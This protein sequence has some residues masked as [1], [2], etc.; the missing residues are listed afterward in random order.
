MRGHPSWN[1]WVAALVCLAA[2]PGRSHASASAAPSADRAFRGSAA[3]LLLPY[4]PLVILGALFGA[5]VTSRTQGGDL[6]LAC[7]LCATTALVLVRQYFALRDH[8][9]LART[10]EL[11]V[12]VRTT[13]LA[14]SEAR[15]RLLAEHIADVVW[16]SDPDG[17]LCYLSPSYDRIGGRP[18]RQIR[19]LEQ[20]FTADG[21]AQ[22]RA[23]LLQ[24]PSGASATR[25]PAL[26][27]QMRFNDR[28]SRAASRMTSTTSSPSS[29]PTRS[30]RF[31]RSTLAAIPAPRSARSESQFAPIHRSSIKF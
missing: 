9:E 27:L 4:V 30:S 10:L 11:K 18:E 8:S 13:A 1:V 16:S 15:Y 12:V 23:A 3:T 28:L 2:V 21:F 26:E 19:S 17:S 24:D 22:I 20:L 7:T 25:P 5:Q 29:S 6:V 14:E 31:R